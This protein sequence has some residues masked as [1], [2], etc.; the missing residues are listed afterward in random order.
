MSETKEII[1]QVLTS[2]DGDYEEEMTEEEIEAMMENDPHFQISD[3]ASG[4]VIVSREL[5]D[6]AANASPK[7]QLIKQFAF[8]KDSVDELNARIEKLD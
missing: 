4:L 5:R 8:I 1:W 3:V 2:N 7:E 6:L